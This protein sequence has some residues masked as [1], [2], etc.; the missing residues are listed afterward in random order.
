MPT[1]NKPKRRKRIDEG[2]RYADD[3]RKIY[4]TIRWRKLRMWKL[5]CNPLCEICVQNGKIVPAEDV[6]HIVSFMS[7]ADPSKRLALAYD[8]D[9]LMSLCK[10]CHQRIHNLK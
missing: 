5:C 1:I 7:T 10:V 8:Y 9:N 4:A 6:H 3:R 2:N